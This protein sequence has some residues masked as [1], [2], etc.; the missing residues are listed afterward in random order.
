M[1]KIIKNTMVDPVEQECPC[2]K[3]V[4]TYNYEDIQRE[5]EMGFLGITRIARRFLVCPV[6]KIEIGMDRIKVEDNDEESG[7]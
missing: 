5:T 6:C 1:I 2:C 4:F 7:D 3:S